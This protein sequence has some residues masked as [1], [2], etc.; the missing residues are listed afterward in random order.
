M[1]PRLLILGG[2]SFQVPL[3]RRAKDR[4]L[5]VITCDYLPD[6]PGHRLAD[7]YHDVST[8][9]REAV[10]AL[11]KRVGIDAVAS[12][13]SDPA[14][15]TVAYVAAAL[16]LPGPPMEAIRR[17]TDKDAFRRLMAEMGL[18]TPRHWTVDAKSAMAA[19]DIA[20]ALPA[21]VSR[22]VVKPVDSSGS[23]GISVIA[24]NSTDLAPALRRALAHSSSKRAIVEE[25]V[26]G[27]QVH[28]DGF[29]HDGRL[30][31]QY[32]G[33]HAFFTKSG[34][35][36]PVST[37]WPSRHGEVV[38]RELV[39]QVEAIA[40]ASGFV[41]GPINIEARVTPTGEVCII[42]IGPRNGG[43]HIPILQHRLTGFDFVEKVLDA[44]LGNPPRLDPAGAPRGV[45]AL[46]ILHADR[47]GT[48][49]GLEV[50][51]EIEDRLLLLDVFKR[52]G[53]P[54]HLYVGSNT[55]LGVALMRF[56]D[57]AERDRSMAEMSQHLR[58]R[59][60]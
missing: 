48:Y 14:M 52:V 53:D 44:A 11:A 1:T 34:A 59:L 7:E 58:L 55:S 43:N 56:D 10:L 39:R 23:R 12:M 16:G 57:I 60:R 15:P 46:F 5:H 32:L 30:V 41:E 25:Y 38:L 51:D 18:P 36:V 45:G 33:D 9:D 22:L 40:R 54:V 21:G 17:L 6:N 26:E 29:L 31:H 2:S 37:S 47:D 4:G 20:T 3:I 35:S 8:T 49:A 13:S 28:G 19:D 50:S 24:R 27:E 42:E